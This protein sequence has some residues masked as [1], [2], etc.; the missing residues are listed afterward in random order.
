[1]IKAVI[2]DDES[3][4][5][6]SLLVL[7]ENYFPAVKVVGTA[8]SAL[9]AVSLVFNEK[10][11]VVFLD[12]NMP[13]HN[14]FDVLDR[15]QSL[16]LKIVFTTAHKEYAI[17]AIKKGAFDY[18]L[19]PID[20]DDLRKCID[21]LTETPKTDEP[22]A[23][24]SGSTIQI[25]VKEG[26][27][28]V[29]TSEIVRLKANGSYTDIYLDHNKKIT[30]SKV[31]KEYENV[32]PPA[33]FYRCHNS[34]IVNLN[35]VEKLLNEDGYFVEFRDGSRAEVSRKNKDELLEKMKVVSVK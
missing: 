21:R 5:I 26:V 17:Q 7:L 6:Q 4:S 20:V 31:L 11:E 1:M 32:L 29:Q 28:F 9:D 23:G 22:R 12:I 10:P 8:A 34:H 2:I 16:P 13:G 25:H 15:I 3:R 27:L 14:G 24:T 19:K 33:H 35:K 30:T 18:L